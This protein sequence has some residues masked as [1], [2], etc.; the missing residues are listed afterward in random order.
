MET[1]LQPESAGQ[2]DQ[3]ASPRDTRRTQYMPARG[4]HEIAETNPDL[5]VVVAEL[6]A[7]A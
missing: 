6:S 1:K 3:I 7:L 5:L 2:A 4:Q